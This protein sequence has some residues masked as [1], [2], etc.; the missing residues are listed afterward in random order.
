MSPTAGVCIVTW[1]SLLKDEVGNTA[2]VPVENAVRS[3]QV[4]GDF[5]AGCLLTIEGSNDGTNWAL[6][7]NISDKLE[8]TQPGLSDIL[9]NSLHVRPRVQGGDERTKLKVILV[10]V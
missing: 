6:L 3:V 10:T 2:S 4:C 9:Q 5:T 1:A 7:S 8:F